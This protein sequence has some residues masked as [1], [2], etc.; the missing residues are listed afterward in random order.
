MNPLPNRPLLNNASVP[1]LPNPVEQMSFNGRPRKVLLEANKEYPSVNGIAPIAGPSSAPAT[2]GPQLPLLERNAVG[3]LQQPLQAQLAP[4]PSL[5]QSGSTG[6]GDKGEDLETRQLT[7]IF[8]PDE[9]WKE[10]LR[11]QAKQSRDIQPTGVGAWDRRRDDDD[12]V[13]DEEPEIEEDETT[14]V[15][16]GE[17]SKTWKAKRTLRKLVF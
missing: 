10:R 14:M 15:G 3:L 4:G 17:T 2:T 7:A 16:D 8:R 11:E 1:P 13:R 9:E 12:D 6:T 5:P